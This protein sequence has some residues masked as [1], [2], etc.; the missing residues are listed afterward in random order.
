[1]NPRSF[2]PSEIIEAIRK[3][4]ATPV[5]LAYLVKCFPMLALE[6]WE[7]A[8]NAFLDK[9]PMEARVHFRAWLDER[10]TPPRNK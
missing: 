6:Y 7:Q 9:L 2:E 1:M 8:G 5:Q 10:S 4:E 3:D